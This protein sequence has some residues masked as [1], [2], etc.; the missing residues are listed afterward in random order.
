GVSFNRAGDRLYVAAAKS[1]LL[2][3]FDTKTWTPV[4]DVPIGS[5]CWHFTFTPDDR[6]ILLACGRSDEV[7]VVDT[8]RLE[9]VERIA[10]KELPW[11]IVTYP[12][13]MGSLDRPE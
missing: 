10:D 2:Q 1:K 6:N 4:K 7:V 9:P 5:R 3:V 8:A 11:G 13:A 12:K